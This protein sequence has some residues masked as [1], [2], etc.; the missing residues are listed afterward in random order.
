MKANLGDNIKLHEA[1]CLGVE[2]INGVEHIA[3]FINDSTMTGRVYMPINTHDKRYDNGSDYKVHIDTF[4]NTISEKF[5]ESSLYKRIFKFDQIASKDN[6]EP[7]LKILIESI[8]NAHR[9][10]ILTKIDHSVTIT[11]E[12]INADKYST[13]DMLTHDVISKYLIELFIL[14]YKH[15]KDVCTEAYDE[16]L[17]NLI[18]DNK[19]NLNIIDLAG[20]KIVNFINNNYREANLSNA[21]TSH[22]ANSLAIKIDW[23]IGMV[24]ALTEDN[25]MKSAHIKDLEYELHKSNRR[26]NQTANSDK[27]KISLLLQEVADLKTYNKEIK[28]RYENEIAKLAKEYASYMIKDKKGYKDDRSKN[29]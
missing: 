3:F 19:Q 8:L 13:D 23:L 4:I 29:K 15:G 22:S 12:L 10:E 20:F 14:F 7:A 21:H 26:N 24:N 18:H 17:S 9:K 11:N 25:K 27:N 2:N 16:L 5:I 28:K 6:I 1:Q